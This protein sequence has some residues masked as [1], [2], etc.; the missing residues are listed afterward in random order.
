MC[1]NISHRIIRSDIVLFVIQ[2]KWTVG[3]FPIKTYIDPF[4]EKDE[5]RGII[6]NCF[7]VSLIDSAGIGF[8]LRMMKYLNLNDGKLALC[9]L[10]RELQKTLYLTGLEKKIAIFDEEQEAVDAILQILG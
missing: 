7:E 5:I 3:G 10:N 6:I 4:L 9:G 8:L 1:M 2:G